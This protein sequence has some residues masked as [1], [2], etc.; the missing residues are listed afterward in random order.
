M[1]LISFVR[2]STSVSRA[3]STA[4]SH[5]IPSEHGWTAFSI[6][7]MRSPS[8]GQPLGVRAVVLRQRLGDQRQAVRVGHQR[9][10]PE[11]LDQA[12]HP[13]GV[14]AGF[15]H[16]PHRDPAAEVALEGR[17][18]GAQLLALDDVAVQI[19]QADVAVLVA[20]V[21]PGYD[22]EGLARSSFASISAAILA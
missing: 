13:V 1:A 5:W 21:D 14:G 9:L 17:G 11:S 15:E 6:S 12:V 10:V 22:V 16:Q 2:V 19:D 18:R 8:F 20:E 3:F 4:R 7:G